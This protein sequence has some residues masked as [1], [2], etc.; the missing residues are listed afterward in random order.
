[1][2]SISAFV[3]VAQ[4]M[5]SARSLYDRAPSG[6]RKDAARLH[7]GEA[8]KAMRTHRDADCLRS[9]SAAVAALR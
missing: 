7:L 4:E 3:S 5:Q 6:S 2:S 8:E 1:M 9:L